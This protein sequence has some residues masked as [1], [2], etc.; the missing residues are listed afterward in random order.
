MLRSQLVWKHLVVKT[1]SNVQD[2]VC[3]ASLITAICPITTF[4]EQNRELQR[5]QATGLVRHEQEGIIYFNKQEKQNQN[6]RASLCF[7]NTRSSAP[8]EQVVA[9]KLTIIL[10]RQLR[11]QSLSPNKEKNISCLLSISVKVYIKCG[12]IVTY[13]CIKTLK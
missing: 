13:K 1:L 12:K 3:K 9:D 8:D 11:A 4:L 10:S 2:D 6:C 5:Q 7:I